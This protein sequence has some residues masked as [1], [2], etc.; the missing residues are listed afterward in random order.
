MDK[1]CFQALGRQ[2]YEWHRDHRIVFTYGGHSKDLELEV[3]RLTGLIDYVKQ[4]KEDLLKK[5]KDI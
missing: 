5:S 4:K 2:F 3:E 1:R